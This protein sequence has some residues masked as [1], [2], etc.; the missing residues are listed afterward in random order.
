MRRRTIALLGCIGLVGCSMAPQTDEQ[1]AGQAQEAANR[2]LGAQA[3]YSEMEAAIVLHI[4]CGHAHAAG[5][6]GTTI[7][8]DF[9][10]RDGKLLM[11]D[12]NGFDAAAAQCDAAVGGAADAQEGARS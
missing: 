3:T 4:A 10:Y 11:E 6:S 1:L 5:P 7:D 12:D 9:V 8:K 2:K